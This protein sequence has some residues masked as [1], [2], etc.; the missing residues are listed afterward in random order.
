MAYWDYERGKTVFQPAKYI[1][2]GWWMVD[3]GCCGGIEWGSLE[4]RE[5]RRCNGFGWLW[6]HEASKTF[7]LYPGGPLRGRGELTK[8][9]KEGGE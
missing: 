4:P 2:D 9:E 5:C 3:C 6:W 7:A 8:L 1:R